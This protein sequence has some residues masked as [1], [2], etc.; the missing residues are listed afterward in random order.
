MLTEKEIV[1]ELLRFDFSEPQARAG[2]KC[3]FKCEYCGRFLLASI[4]DYDTWQWDHL[5][6]VSKGGGDEEENGAI[7]CKLCNFMKRNFLPSAPLA[8][9]GRRAYIEEVKTYL[10]VLRRQKLEKLN[11]IRRIAGYEPVDG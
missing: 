4:Q 6:P 1:S 7:A 2:I 10:L 5:E 9:L 11:N 3:E 8:V